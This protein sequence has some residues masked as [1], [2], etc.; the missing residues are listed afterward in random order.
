MSDELLA[1]PHSV[2]YADGLLMAVSAA[3]YFTCPG[4][5]C[6]GP[7]TPLSPLERFHESPSEGSIQSGVGLIR[8][9]A[10]DADDV[11]ISIDDGAPIH[12]GYGTSREDTRGSAAMPTMATGW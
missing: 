7:A 10:C 8:G 2:L 1:V 4:V 12:I 3:G 6:L 9:W 11:A 5:D